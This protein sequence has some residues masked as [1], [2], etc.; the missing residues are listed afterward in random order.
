MHRAIS[1]GFKLLLLVTSFDCMNSIVDKNGATIGYLHQNIIIDEKQDKVLGIILGN[2]VFGGDKAPIGKFFNNTFR[3]KNGKII[4][5][6]GTEVISKKNPKDAKLTLE[7]W[8]LLTK[9]KDHVCMWI[10]EKKTWTKQGFAE[11]L[12]VEKEIPGDD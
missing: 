5:K 3:K 9:V 12:S 10:E 4:A 8:Q 7:A 11:Y 2:C 1:A 6:L